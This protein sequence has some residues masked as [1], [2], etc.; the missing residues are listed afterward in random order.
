MDLGR[1]EWRCGIELLRLECHV[2]DLLEV[3]MDDDRGMTRVS[4]YGMAGGNCGGST[5]P[6]GAMSGL[7]ANHWVNILDL[8]LLSI[9]MSLRRL[10]I[11]AYRSDRFM[12]CDVAEEVSIVFP[13]GN[14]TSMANVILAKCGMG[15]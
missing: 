4:T 12:F 8:T 6:D 5:S 2:I 3:L 7:M 1:E 15:F 9:E 10:F 11:Q 14:S 13:F